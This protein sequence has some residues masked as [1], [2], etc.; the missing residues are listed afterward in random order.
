MPDI[1]KG[2]LVFNDLVVGRPGYFFYSDSRFR[3]SGLF[4]AGVTF[5]TEPRVN[6][7]G[8]SQQI[9]EES[10]TAFLAKPSMR[11]SYQ[12]AKQ[13]YLFLEASA[14]YQHTRSTILNSHFG[15]TLAIGVDTAL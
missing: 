12:A 6:N 4:Q 2:T 14:L 3:L 13:L 7:I 9:R 10:R 11:L 1:S 8:S 15:S 5:W